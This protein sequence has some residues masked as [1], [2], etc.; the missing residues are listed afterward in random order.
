MQLQKMLFSGCLLI[1][2]LAGAC[3][4]DP[5]GSSNTPAPAAGTWVV[6][7]FFDDKE[8]TANYTDYAFEFGADGSLTV[9]QGGLTFTGTWATGT[10]DSKEKFV[11]NFS[12]AIPSELE[13][14]A[15]DW[16][17]VVYEDNFMHFEHTSGGNGDTDVLKFSKL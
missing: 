15:E 5:S 12:G 13:E 17:I 10:D 11:I 16:Q 14:L 2:L 3:K 9:K 6:S 4:K 1:G 8:E 7:Y